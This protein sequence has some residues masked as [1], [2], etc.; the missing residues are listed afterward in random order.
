MCDNLLQPA[1]FAVTYE[2]IAMAESYLYMAELSIS[3]DDPNPC[4]CGVGGVLGVKRPSPTF[5]RP[6]DT[7]DSIRPTEECTPSNHVQGMRTRA[8]SV[9]TIAYC[10]AACAF[11]DLNFSMLVPFFPEVARAK[12]CSQFLVGCLFSLHQL[13][14]LL[15]TPL[16]PTLIRW[17]GGGRVLRLALA[18]QSATAFAFA[19]TDRTPT[20]TTFVAACVI[21]RCAQG[22]CA[23]LSEVSAVGLLMRSVPEDRVGH[24]IGWSEA[25]RGIGIMVGPMLGG[26]MDQTLGFFAPFCTS[27]ACLALLALAM[28]MVPEH[29]H[30]SSTGESGGPTN[31]F[32]LLL[33]APVVV[34]SLLIAFVLMIVITFIDPTI[35]PFMA[36]A[37][38][39]LDE[40][41]VGLVYSCSLLVYSFVSLYAGAIAA[42]AGN[43]ATLTVGMLLTACSYFTL[44]P[45]PGEFDLSRLALVPFLERAVTDHQLAIILA[46]T[47]LSVMGFGTA[48]AFVPANSLMVA[49]AEVVGL[50]VD[51]SSDPI[52]ALS[53]IAFTG[54]AAIGPLLGGAMVQASGFRRASA[55]FGL[56][57]ALSGCVL[58]GVISLTFVRRR[59][60]RKPQM[61]EALIPV[62]RTAT[63]S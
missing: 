32:R 9:R 45:V 19:F 34:S 24:A 43:L 55:T 13:C 11:S 29:H 7:M 5:L 38:F 6:P 36:K 42:R 48:L 51:A 54:G 57:L 33:C 8:M 20:K 39:N 16:A 21:L 26:G 10:C 41:H 47:S 53:M 15:V 63:H 60:R 14:S 28:T 1:R 61:A 4:A 37:P 23:G 25:A 2:T 12:G 27:G 49:E 58:L 59:R 3:V 40:F 22:L 30:S 35:Q 56:G 31:S 50:S 62:E 17:F 46:T 44:A 18:S 52:A